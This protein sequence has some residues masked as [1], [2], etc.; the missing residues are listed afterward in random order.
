MEEKKRYSLA[1]VFTKHETNKTGIAL[2]AIVTY[3][4]NENEALGLA[5]EELK[6]EMKSHSLEMYTII[7]IKD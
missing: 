2:R 1:F 7:E 4:Y 3:A 5:I 6:S